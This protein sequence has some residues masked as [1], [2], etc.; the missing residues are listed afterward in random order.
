MIKL[1]LGHFLYFHYIVVQSYHF[2]SEIPTFRSQIGSQKIR[3]LL[4]SLERRSEGF[5]FH[6]NVV[7]WYKIQQKDMRCPGLMTSKKNLWN[8]NLE[9]S[10]TTLAFDQISFHSSFRQFIMHVFLEHS[11]ENGF[12][13]KKWTKNKDKKISWRIYH[14]SQFS[15]IYVEL[16]LIGCAD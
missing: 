15:P 2:L 10:N 11:I 12:F 4:W 7:R 1:K 14:H 9:V 6:Y 8:C 5:N 13:L 3:A 16:G